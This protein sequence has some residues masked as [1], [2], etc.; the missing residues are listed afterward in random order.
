MNETLKKFLVCLIYVAI[1]AA[2]FIAYEP[3]RHNGFVDY[4]DGNYVFNN[5]HVNGGI[6]RQSLLWA[7]TAFHAGNWHPLTWLSHMLDCDLFG[8]DA[9]WHHLSSL[10]IHTAAALLLF[11]L[12]KT[13]TGA[14]GTSA[15][16][17]AAF[18]LHPLHVES[19]AWIAE[20]KDVLSALFCM[21]TIAS[22]VRYARRPGLGRYLLVTLLFSLG[23][24]AK[25]MLVT[26]PFI[27]LLLDY[28]P[29]NRLQPATSVNSTNR[30]KRKSPSPAAHWPA[31][32]RLLC[33]KLPFLALSVASAAVTF[34][35]QKKG[36]A[37]VTLGYA[38]PTF[39]IGNAL[40]SYARYIG[41]TIWPAHLAVIY[42]NPARSLPP[43]K[44]VAAAFLLLVIS[45]CAIRLARNRK[46]L[47]VGWLWYLGMLVPVIG[48]IQVG[49]QVMADRYTYL[50][51]IGLF[52]MI[53]WAAA[54]LPARRQF[55]KIILPPLAA[56][57]L[58]A[59]LVCTRVQVGHWK[60]SFTLFAHAAAVTKNNHVALNNFAWHLATA[61][62]PQHR[63]PAEAI[64]FA[65][66]A[67]EL[68]D[69]N[70][71]YSLDTLA[72]AHAAAGDF[73]RAIQTADRAL[74]L[75]VALGN[76]AIADQIRKHLQLYKA[77]EPL[78]E[79][80]GP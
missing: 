19:V 6:T 37:V 52:I 60:D 77:R 39:R 42:A 76:A 44:V 31:L 13:A 33:E 40:L 78:I 46:Y 67:C 22:Y 16:V 7:F 64:K 8:L 43:W 50:P 49:E 57:F 35:A 27:L 38:S 68:T 23:L 66:Q 36:G 61:P 80:S 75:A 18:A 21:L 32:S 25:P 20:R 10:L 62:D 4:D 2:A 48:L 56:I 70:W 63:N 69:Y 71:V 3:L 65:K 29:L 11:S 45:I 15:F 24:M 73:D 72:A 54:E 14:V 51:S 58:T 55:K 17:A 1:A 47:P 26:L 41:K 30:R 34:L 5:P 74:K 53:A 9:P 28:W 79:K 12:L 59:M